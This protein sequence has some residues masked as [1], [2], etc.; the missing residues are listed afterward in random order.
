MVF[1][2]VDT[3]RDSTHSSCPMNG[4]GDRTGFI[5]ESRSQEIRTNTNIKLRKGTERAN[6][7]EMPPMT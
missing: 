7:L 6:R 4:L 3:M 2:M 1:G 5:M